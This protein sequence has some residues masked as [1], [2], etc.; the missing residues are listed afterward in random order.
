MEVA[1]RSVALAARLP[2]LVV[3]AAAI[4]AAQTSAPPPATRTQ[5]IE[6]ARDKKR[7]ALHP[8]E[9]SRTEAFLR[10]LKEKRWLER[11][12]TGYNGWRAKVGNVVTGGGFAI[13]PEYY[14]EDLM[15]GNLVAR[16]SAQFTTRGYTKYEA[17]ASLPR[18]WGDHLLLDFL[19][20]RRNYGGLPYYGP[21]P[22]SEKSRRTNYRLEDTSFDAIAALRPRRYFKLGGSVGAL[23]VNVGPGTDDRYASTEEVFGPAQ[24]PGINQQTDHLRTGVFGQFD[25]RD[26]PL[27]PK[28]GGNYVLQYSW[29]DDR[30]LGVFGFR[31]MDLDLQQYVPFLNRTHRIALRAKGT[32]TESDGTQTTPFYLRPVL[33]GS[34]DL[35]GYR[36]FRFSDRNMVVYNA[37]Y[38]WEI[39]AGMDGALFFD[40]GKVMPRRSLLA[41]SDL[42]TSAGFG[43][44]FNV[45][46]A[47]FLRIDVGFSHEGFQV[48]F[49]F[50]DVFISRP[51]GTTTGQP[52]Y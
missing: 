18:L 46:N 32:F 27:G 52:V 51:F 19:G 17:Q 23:W 28:A 49:K 47:T 44:R 7:A 34:D 24:A 30:K 4:C 21:G 40:A 26:D 6:Q 10:D 25:Y 37:E 1:A 14:R 48:W 22:D 38:Q 31:R 9:V 33:G 15:R 43:L 41:F 13:G 39:F 3:A 16:G 8:D 2:F 12:A 20:S 36:P 11:W 45:R 35:R 50:N 42:E 5:E 29:Y